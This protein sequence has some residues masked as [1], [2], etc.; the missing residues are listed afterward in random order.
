MSVKFLLFLEAFLNHFS[1][2]CKMAEKR[3]SYYQMVNSLPPWSILK[4]NCQGLPADSAVLKVA[5]SSQENISELE[6]LVCVLM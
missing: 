1:V 3:A 2:L 6:K 5:N 4:K